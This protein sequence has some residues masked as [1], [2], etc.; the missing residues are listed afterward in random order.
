MAIHTFSDIYSCRN[1]VILETCH[2]SSKLALFSHRQNAKSEHKHNC[3]CSLKIIHFYST[4]ILCWKGIYTTV[5]VHV[6]SVIFT[7]FTVRLSLLVMIEYYCLYAL[8]L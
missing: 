5:H 1:S 6:G 7:V 3:F 8:L 2:F 4:C